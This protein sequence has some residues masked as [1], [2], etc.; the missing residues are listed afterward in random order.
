MTKGPIPDE[1]PSNL[2]E[3]LLLEDAKA[4]NAIPI[5]GG[6]RRPL[7]DVPRLVA[8][9]GGQPEDWFKMTSNEAFVINGASVQVHWFRN[10]QTGQN[11]EIKFKRNYPKTAPKN[12]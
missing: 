2:Q 12:Q 5:Q 1:T 3:Q 7:G 8:I 11:V 6:A 10:N 4:G 9:Y